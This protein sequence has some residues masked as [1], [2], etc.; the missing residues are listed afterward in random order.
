MA[1]RA[2]RAWIAALVAV[3]RERYPH[4]GAPGAGVGAHG[5]VV[6]DRTHGEA[7]R[8]RPR[9]PWRAPE[10][11][12]AHGRALIER[13]SAAMAL[14]QVDA[15]DARRKTR[16]ACTT[17]VKPATGEAEHTIEWR[18]VTRDADTGGGTG[19]EG[20][21]ALIDGEGARR[22][23]ALAEEG[24]GPY[25]EMTSIEGALLRGAANDAAQPGTHTTITWRK[26]AGGAWAR[27]TERDWVG[28]EAFGERTLEAAFGAQATER[29]LE[30]AIWMR[31]SAR[32]MAEPTPPR[33]LA[34]DERWKDIWTARRR[35]AP[36]A[37]R[38]GGYIAEIQLDTAGGTACTVGLFAERAGAAHTAVIR[39]H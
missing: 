29:T 13:A 18:L 3:T 16:I 10:G 17:L 27:R 31:A 32:E 21:A 7:A 6:L 4:G 33:H 5:Q 2:A 8:S 37:A 25:L 30:R 19:H 24:D 39:A 35:K 15:T 22:T 20:R 26:S 38:G 9:T 14:G 23:V 12:E 28:D 36:R 11:G 34:R 1:T